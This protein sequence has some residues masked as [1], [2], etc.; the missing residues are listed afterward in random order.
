MQSHTN[1]AQF[2]ECHLHAVIDF[3][4]PDYLKVDNLPVI[5]H[6]SLFPIIVFLILIL[7]VEYV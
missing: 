4:E 3:D 2:C 5:N 1:T 6:P 7:Y